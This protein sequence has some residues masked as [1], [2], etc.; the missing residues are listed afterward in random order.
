MESE[1]FVQVRVWWPPTRNKKRTDFSGAYWPAKVVDSFD[2]GYRVEYDNLERE[3]V[4][5]EDVSPANPPVAFGEE[6]TPLAVT[7]KNIEML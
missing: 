2:G 7:S 6:T 4:D 3:D 1:I 5:S